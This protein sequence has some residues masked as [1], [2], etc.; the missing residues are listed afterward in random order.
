MYC[1]QGET[2]RCKKVKAEE[3]TILVTTDLFYPAVF[4]LCFHYTGAPPNYVNEV[5]NFGF[6]IEVRPYFCAKVFKTDN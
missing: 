5:F 1:M 6:S 4:M 2:R 3:L